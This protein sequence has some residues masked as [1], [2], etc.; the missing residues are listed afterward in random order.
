MNLGQAVS[1]LRQAAVIAALIMV[2]LVILAK[3]LGLRVVQIPGL[4]AY[5]L[6]GIAAVLWATR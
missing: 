6:G 2:L 5:T 3:G 4:D 1:I